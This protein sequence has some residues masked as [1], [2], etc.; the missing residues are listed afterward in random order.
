MFGQR[1]QYFMLL[2][3]NNNALPGKGK[4]LRNGPAS[5]RSGTTYSFSKR[6]RVVVAPV[7]MVM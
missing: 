7:P 1:R 2:P 3:N 6:W 5:G 4:A